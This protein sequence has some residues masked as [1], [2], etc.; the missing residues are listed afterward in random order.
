MGNI[1][2]ERAAATR[3][4]AQK[5]GRVL[6]MISVGVEE[7]EVFR[8]IRRPNSTITTSNTDTAQSKNYDCSQSLPHIAHENKSD[9]L[10]STVFHFY[11]AL[12]G[13]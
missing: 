7:E 5:S 10:S 1:I 12:S 4:A 9:P 13:K 3:G 2:S 8:R 11:Q 6:M